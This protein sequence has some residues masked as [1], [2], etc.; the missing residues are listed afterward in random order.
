MK[1]EYELQRIHFINICKEKIVVQ[2]RSI[3]LVV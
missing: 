3:L 1:Q 2:K